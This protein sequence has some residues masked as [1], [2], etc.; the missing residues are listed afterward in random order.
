VKLLLRQDVEGVGHKGDLVDVADGYARNYLVPK[1]LALKATK[2][3]E[4]QAEAMRRNRELKD[5]ADREQAE[6]A[7]SRLVP[8]SI[9]IAARAGEGGKLFGSVTAADIATAVVDQSG[10]EI[11]R[12]AIS[13][14]DPIRL[15]GTHSVQVRL[16][17]EVEFPLTVE[18]TAQD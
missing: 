12:R 8:T 14:A 15:L 9:S 10:I 17:A 4:V 1:G 6:E 16:H 2:G 18:V 3:A 7:A 5:T 13:L 11:D